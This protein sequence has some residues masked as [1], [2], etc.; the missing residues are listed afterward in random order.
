MHSL[1]LAPQLPP[2][3]SPFLKGLMQQECDPASTVK[4]P[5]VEVATATPGNSSYYAYWVEDQGVKVDL[6]WNEGNFSD[7][8]R[9]QAARLSTAPGPDHAVFEGPFSSGVSYP[10]EKGSGYVDGLEKAFSSADMPLVM[11]LNN[12][13][14]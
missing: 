3:T 5:K 9:Q 10:L 12:K 1:M 11:G 6:A 4:V 14:E 7:A 2:T 8:D 13:P